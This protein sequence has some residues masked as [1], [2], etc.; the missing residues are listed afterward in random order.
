MRWDIIFQPA[1]LAMYGEGVLTTLSLLLS[2][3]AIGGVL[4]VVFALA[5]TQGP[6]PLRWLVGGYTYVIRGTPLLIQMYMIYY[7][8]AQLEW[9]QARW[10]AV[11]P[12]TMFKDA[13]FC[14]LL[15]FSLN[16]AGYTAEMLAGSIRETAAGEIEAA[17]AMGMG[18][19]QALRRIVLPSAMRRTLPAYSNE[20]VMMLHST[21]LASAVPAMLD[22]TA[23]ASRIY[24]DF[25]L[26]FEAYIF[27]AAIYLTITFT[28]VGVFKL[29]E[30]HFL[31]HLAPR[32]H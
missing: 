31:A 3:L 22:V 29:S 25:Y 5:L 30:R 13:F 6:A 21:S 17:Q 8:L 20:V 7:G 1:H 2:C 9:I 19:W 18:R 4:A 14:A 10:D 26:P 28:L 24:S 16:T 15:A 23:A 12:W 11:W 32:A 27:A